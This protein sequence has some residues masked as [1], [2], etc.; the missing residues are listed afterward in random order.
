MSLS[1]VKRLQN[2]VNS[3]VAEILGDYKPRPIRGNKVIRDT[4]F[5]FNVY[6]PH[7]INILDSPL[8]QRLRSIR[9]TSLAYF[10][11]P[12]AV[13]T[14]FEH[15]L[16]ATVI[17]ARMVEALKVRKSITLSDPLVCEVRLAA[18]L[19]DVGHGPFSHG[20]EFIFQSYKEIRNVKNEEAL[21]RSKAAH[22]ILSYF[23]VNSGEFD[24]LWKNVKLLYLSNP[25]ICPCNLAEINL[26]TVA[27]M[28]LGE[29]PEPDL[30]YLAQMVNGPHDADK[31]DYI[32]RD[33]YFTGLRTAI[34]I[35]RFFLSLNIHRNSKTKELA[36][37][38]DL[39]GV[40]A[41]E[42]LLFNK[43]QLFSSVYH[44]HKVRAAVQALLEVFNI[45]KKKK[46]KTYRGL[47][48]N[49]VVDFLKVNDQDILGIDHDDEDFKRAVE[50]LKN[51]LL[52][53]RALVLCSDSV[54]NPASR[55]RLSRMT[56]DPLKIQKLRKDIAKKAKE[57]LG[58]VF[59][60]F[61]EQPRFQGT[62]FGSQVK[63]TPEDVVD[64]NSIFPIGGWVKGHAEHRYRAYIFS[65]SGKEEKV[66]KAAYE[67]LKTKEYGIRVKKMAFYLANH[68]PE[69][70]A[71]LGLK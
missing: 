20:S 16:G 54:Q 45:Y 9:Q 71:S 4:A 47:T 48:F 8:L 40:T 31:F 52:P 7:E 26:K 30:K 5:G 44:H 24:K 21:F 66:A 10:T 23:I 49:Q 39:S 35:D 13:H 60:D 55:L 58:D 42:Q 6:Y 38:V 46:L 32:I 28:I 2:Q 70:V 68:S 56:K 25:N 37:C 53:M 62:A 50:A 59:I 18:L 15:S 65:S 17:V 33:G 29:H 51:R 34:D 1:A 36:M 41:L 12:S 64:L 43:M 57:P 63:T 22:E 61:P 69:F 3:T 19:H 27:Q 11:Y 14:R 67:V